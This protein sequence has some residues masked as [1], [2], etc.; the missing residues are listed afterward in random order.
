MHRPFGHEA[1]YRGASLVPLIL[2]ALVYVVVASLPNRP[3]DVDRLPLPLRALVGVSAYLWSSLLIAEWPYAVF[4]LGSLILLR[5]RTELAYHRFVWC[6]PLVF[7]AFLSVWLGLSSLSTP[8]PKDLMSLVGAPLYWSSHAVVLGYCY[9]ILV[10]LL[11]KGFSHHF[12][13]AA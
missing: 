10:Q 2:P 8:G 5:H 11:R 1:F 9:V 12:R 13:P 6:S 4:A 7:A 3:I